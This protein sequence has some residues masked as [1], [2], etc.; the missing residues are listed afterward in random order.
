MTSSVLKPAV[1]KS[2]LTSSDHSEPTNYFSAYPD[3]VPI[4]DHPAWGYSVTDDVDNQGLRHEP[5]SHTTVTCAYW[6]IWQ[7]T[8]CQFWSGHS[9]RLLQRG[10]FLEWSRSRKAPLQTWRSA[11]DLLVRRL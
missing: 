7:N 3:N 2:V 4:N 1:C 11:V 5:P 8:G 9:L 6:T 10:E